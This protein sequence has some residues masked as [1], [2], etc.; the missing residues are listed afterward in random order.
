MF[1]YQN[2]K[3]P[4]ISGRKL[5]LLHLHSLKPLAFISVILGIAPSSTMRVL[6]CAD[7]F[8]EANVFL[9]P[10][11]TPLNSKTSRW[12]LLYVLVTGLSM[13]IWNVVTFY[14]TFVHRKRL[15]GHPTYLYLV[16][17]VCSF[18]VA[19]VSVLYIK[20]YRRKHA[21]TACFSSTV[22]EVDRKIRSLS[23]RIVYN[24]SGYKSVILKLF[25]T[26]VANA[27]LYSVD[28]SAADSDDLVFVVNRSVSHLV[29]TI[30]L[31]EFCILLDVVRNRF[32][33]IN[34]IVHE[35]VSHGVYQVGHFLKW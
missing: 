8:V 29:S 35:V 9:R 31:L 20:A 2:V 24:D 15:Q 21:E 23:P 32:K 12:S 27:V 11:G 26:G 28:I 17:A 10:A 33:V 14:T 13:N 3:M 4:K 19:P 30:A 5:T 34:D 16:I 22:R 7:M 18:L 6:T 1:G 25:L